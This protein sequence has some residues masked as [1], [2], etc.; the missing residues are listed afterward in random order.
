MEQNTQDTAENKIQYKKEIVDFLLKKN[1]LIS[2]DF[3]KNL[4]NTDIS[5]LK[6][7][8]EKIKSTDILILNKEVDTL[9][10]NNRNVK[11]NW[12]EIEKSKVLYE[13]GKDT[14]TYSKFVDYIEK[15][16]KTEGLKVEHKKTTSSV[17]VLFSYEKE[18][19][20]RE[21][22][23]FVKYFNVRYF[24]IERL[25]KNRVEMQNLTS[26][27]RILG[28][29]EKEN[30]SFVGMV[31]EK[32]E[33]KNKN[34]MLVL[35]DPTGVIKAIV[36]KNKQDL[37]ARAKDIVFDEVIGIN[38]AN[39]ENAV[40]V[41]NLVHP[42]V[43]VKELKK[44]KDEVYALFLSDLHVGSTNFLEDE[45]NKFL[46]W[47][48]C[49]IGSDEQRKIAGKVKYIFILGD[50][51]D[52]CGIYP[53]QD[54]E[55]I[56]KDVYQQYEVCAD[57]LKK[58]PQHMQLIVCPGN[59]DAMRISEPQPKIFQDLAPSLWAMPNITM[60]S[61]PSMINMHADDDFPGFDVLLYH[62]YSFDY[63]V[64]EVESIRNQGRYNRADLIMKF[65]LQRRHLAPSHTS[66]LYIPDT[67]SDPLV[68]EK[69]P[70]FFVTGHIHK[71]IA[72][73]YKN[74]TTISGS[75]WQS[76]TSFQEKVGHNPEPA[77]VPIVNLQTREIKILKFG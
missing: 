47:I 42:D 20:K 62:G 1:V 33:T 51:I 25:L 40:F 67:E 46:K 15:N 76:K 39:V 9:F 55:L 37:Y 32:Q 38:G 23:D 8:F 35:E 4:E 17:K 34:I 53:N 75:C 36:S 48:N 31:K 61:N 63:Y 12:I 10:E 57:F 28:K 52:G 74:I 22:E 59:H 54:K 14:K 6:Q 64:A 50:L 2:A 3:I 72:A 58:I 70:D 56:I 16:E 5:Y 73:N 66:T 71:S 41:N 27:S 45:F 44:S 68:I 30:V 18:A 24:A 69:I 65:L 13:K 29:K 60:V 7:L 19:K 21:I 11:E 49:E 26:I 43:P 77:R